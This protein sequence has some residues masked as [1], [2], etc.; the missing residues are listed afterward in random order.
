MASSQL[1]ITPIDLNY[2]YC[3][4]ILDYTGLKIDRSNEIKSLSTLGHLNINLYADYYNKIQD[5][6]LLNKVWFGYA[7]EILDASCLMILYSAFLKACNIYLNFTTRNKIYN[8][9]R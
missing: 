4:S 7:F 5:S 8:V 1:T 3:S 9:V 2:N 6:Q